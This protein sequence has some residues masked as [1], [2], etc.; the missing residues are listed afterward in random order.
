MVRIINPSVHF[1]RRL[2]QSSTDT[3]SPTKSNNSKCTEAN[4]SKRRLV[5]KP[6]PSKKQ[7]GTLA[8]AK[9][10]FGY[11]ALLLNM[12]AD[13]WNSSSPDPHGPR[14]QMRANIKWNPLRQNCFI[15]VEFKFHLLESLIFPFLI[16]SQ[17]WILIGKYEGIPGYLFSSSQL[18]FHWRKYVIGERMFRVSLF[19]SN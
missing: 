14:F 19:S 18:I 13:V 16:R 9:D 15:R 11:Q 1:I 7:E 8:K 10:C 12:L 3:R 2:F 6:K 17:G 4:R 5:Q